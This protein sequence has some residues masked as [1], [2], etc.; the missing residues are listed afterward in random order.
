MPSGLAEYSDAVLAHFRRPRNAGRFP[1]GCGAVLEGHA[2]VRRHGR[3]V[4]IQL[5]ATSDERIADCR[6]RVYGCPATIA[7]CSLASEALKGRSL[8]EAAE[9]SALLL[10][11]ELDL[12]AEKR[13]AALTVEDAIRAAAVRYNAP[14]VPVPPVR[15]QQS[16]V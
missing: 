3:E 4:T 16:R 15:N 12:P 9:F 13:D 1:Q 14:Q 6:Y 10:A 2:G 5:Q 11:D 8:A 7:L